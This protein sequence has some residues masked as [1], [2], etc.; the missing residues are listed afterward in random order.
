MAITASQI[1]RIFIKKIYNPN[2]SS[3]FFKIVTTGESLS[4]NPLPPAIFVCGDAGAGDWIH[5][6]NTFTERF[7][8]IFGGEIEYVLQ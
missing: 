2:L 8:L 1:N 7:H 6:I 4:L 3:A 5:T